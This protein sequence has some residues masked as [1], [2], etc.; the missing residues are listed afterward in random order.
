MSNFNKRKAQKEQQ[1]IV[2]RE[3]FQPNTAEKLDLTDFLLNKPKE[4]NAPPANEERLVNLPSSAFYVDPQVRKIIE[5]HKI[6]ERAASFRANGQL[7][8]IT[9]FPADTEG[10][11]KGKH[12]IYV[13]E[14][15]W[16]AAQLID[17]F[18]LKALIDPA[19][20]SKIRRSY[21]IGQ[22]V[23]NEQHLYLKPLEVAFALSE[24]MSEA[25]T[26]MEDI[27]RDLGWLTESKKPNVNKVSRYLSI[28]KLPEEGVSLVEDEVVTDITTLEFLRK[29]FEINPSKFSALCDLAREDG[30]IAR[31]R[32]EQE[33]KQCKAN[34]APAVLSKNANGG[35]GGEQ[36]SDVTTEPS[37]E[38]SHVRMEGEGSI[39][40]PGTTLSHNAV[41][42][43]L[44]P[45][46]TGSG[47]TSPTQQTTPS[48]KDV[49]LKEP[50]EKGSAPSISEFQPLPVIQ[51]S[52][53]N[54]KK[55][56]LVLTGVQEEKGHAW[57]K[58]DSGDV[59]LAELDELKLK[60]ITFH[61]GT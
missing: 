3:A 11:N 6:E 59:I 28:L 57:V 43:G 24:L 41:T 8:P 35:A 26:T 60:A 21:I 33:Y 37:N 15:R 25:G 23:E 36:D 13:G 39:E 2:D 9:V 20:P 48:S 51:V 53:Q 12:K 32:A 29:I 14:C 4:K 17:G 54:L 58:L 22:V 1:K 7:Q 38:F 49:T 55:G 52:W 19:L 30:G 45:N 31:K 44:T 50:K 10:P 47:A 5:P 34:E 42:S 18:L 16:R 46:S 56:V 27:A 61:K 40:L